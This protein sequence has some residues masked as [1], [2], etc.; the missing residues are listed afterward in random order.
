VR[1]LLRSLNVTTVDAALEIVGR[2]FD[3]ESLVSRTQLALEEL[4]QGGLWRERG[5]LIALRNSRGRVR[6]VTGVAEQ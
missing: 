3:L 4:P 1:Y 6:A 5:H 2:C